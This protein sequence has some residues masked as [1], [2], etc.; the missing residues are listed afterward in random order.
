M[1]NPKINYKQISRFKS[2][3][4]FKKKLAIFIWEITYYSLFVWT[5]KPLN[6]ENFSLKLFKCKIYG[7]QL[8]I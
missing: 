5:P 2:P 1:P 8:S 4:S 7:Y 3:W 6:M